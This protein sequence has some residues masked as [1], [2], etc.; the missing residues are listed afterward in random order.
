MHTPMTST[1]SIEG[2]PTTTGILRRLTELALGP[3]VIRRRLPATSGGGA[4]LV[5]ADVG[6]GLGLA[7]VSR[8]R[9]AD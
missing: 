9:Q 1:S 3:I 6:G 7:V 4:L 2:M 8:G 5:S